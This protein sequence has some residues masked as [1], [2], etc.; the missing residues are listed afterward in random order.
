MTMQAHVTWFG[1]R[2]VRVDVA[3]SGE[4]RSVAAHLRDRLPGMLVRP[5]MRSVLV[6]APAPDPHLLE[7]VTAVLVDVRPT[8]GDDDT[9]RLVEIPVT[10]RGADLESVAA[11]LACD[12]ETLVRAHRAQKW[13]VAMMGF[14]PGFGYLEPAGALQLPWQDIPRRDS[15]RARVPAGSVAVAAGMS[16]VYPESMPGGWHLIGTTE[17]T[18]FDPD[19]PRDPSALLPGDTVRFVV[20]P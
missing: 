12:V 11:V 5:G 8:A 14:A 3:S 19:S 15:P 6:E 9:G 1:D 2:A 17:V 4:R 18:L 10:Y 20:Q 7:S 13:I 16:A